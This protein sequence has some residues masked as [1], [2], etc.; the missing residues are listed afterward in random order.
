M[1][2]PGIHEHHIRQRRSDLV[3][4][5]VPA[6]AG[7]LAAFY[8]PFVFFNGELLATTLVILLQLVLALQLLRS[9]PWTLTAAALAGLT[10][11]LLVSTRGNTLLI[12]PLA[13]WWI[14]AETRTANRRWLP[15]LAF[16]GATVLLLAP[17][18]LRNIAVQRV[19]VPFQGRWSLYQGTNQDADGTPY[20]RQGLSWQRL[21]SLPYAEGHDTPANRGRYFLDASL[22]F[23]AEQPTAY[24]SLLYQKF[25]LFW[26]QFEIPVS[27]DLRYYESHS[28]LSRW[29]LTFGLVVPLALA[30]AAWYRRTEREF[31]LLGGLVL[32]YLASGMTFTVCARYRLPALPFLLLFAANGVWLTWSLI[33]ERNAVRLGTFLLI[34]AGAFLLVHTG[35][36]AR[37][38]DHL[39]SNWLQS[40]VHLRNGDYDRAQAAL[41]RELARNPSDS[42]V[43]NSLAGLFERQDR[44]D[45][46]EPTLRRAL[47]A[48]PDHAL[49][50]LNLGDFFL[51]DRR[52]GSAREAYAAALRSDPRP[53]TQYRGQ[54]S[55]GDLRMLSGDP[56]GAR[57][58]FA[59]AARHRRTPHIYYALSSAN[60]KLGRR[61]EQL[62]AL[63]HAVRLD[64]T[65]A[66]ALR[67]LGALAFA[68]GDFERAEH[69]LVMA[70]RRDPG[71]AHGYRNLGMVYRK[72]GD[73]ERANL[74]FAEARRLAADR[75]APD[76]G[77]AG[78]DAV[79]P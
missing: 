20:A 26:H 5:Q 79:Q 23:I 67:N 63:E 76:A 45:L 27:V 60:A 10:M 61:T 13:L 65:F 53:V 12:L 72:L 56:A 11:A 58:A 48:A 25:R 7:L 55:M 14:S 38:V 28:R 2:Q 1:I 50:W 21:E 69:L 43:L 9:G 59:A 42:D 6:I 41:Q 68:D 57:Q 4:A 8:W 15:S 33:R 70:V 17:F 71:S 52:L 29:L 35:V 19:P 31:L 54:R 24:V 36:D 34:A 37:S 18:A 78:N 16:L 40:Q 22:A 51:R 73:Y 3:P 49:P 32:A 39:R 66:P 75:L 47:A 62:E 74:A 30:A 64:S 77:G 46:I 44:R